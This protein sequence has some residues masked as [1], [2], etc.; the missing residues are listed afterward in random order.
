M[1]APAPLG[2]GCSRLRAGKQ[3]GAGR[4]AAWD[5]SAAEGTP[6]PPGQ[7]SLDVATRALH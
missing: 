6:Q 4:E 2:A 5:S 3:P 1:S 7:G